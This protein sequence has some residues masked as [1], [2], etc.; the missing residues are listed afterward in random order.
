[1][2]AWTFCASS[3]CR[4]LLFRR[5]FH[6][7][8]RHCRG[9]PDDA[10]APV[11][12]AAAQRGT[13]PRASSKTSRIPPATEGRCSTNKVLSLPVMCATDV[14]GYSAA[15][16]AEALGE[17]QWRCAQFCATHFLCCAPATFCSRRT[18][19]ATPRH[20]RPV[21][22]LTVR[23]RGLE[24]RAHAVPSKHLCIGHVTRPV[25]AAFADRNFTRRQ[26][27]RNILQFKICCKRLEAGRQVAAPSRRC[28]CVCHDSRPHIV[29]MSVLLE[30]VEVLLL[31]F[32][33][34]SGLRTSPAPTVRLTP[35]GGS[36]S[37]ASMWWRSAI[38]SALAS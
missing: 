30:R 1:M 38:T 22:E 21:D 14:A 13:R 7:V 24:A 10:T 9:S 35:H 37:V 28:H 8:G 33:A 12:L 15:P 18:L 32:L 20:Y 36:R 3:H 31:P 2:R 11:S 19:A 23:L 27:V 29:M 17:A 34:V 26:K 6:A 16:E 25:P 4:G 5:V